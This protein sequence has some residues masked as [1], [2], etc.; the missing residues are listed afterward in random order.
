MLVIEDTNFLVSALKSTDIF[1]NDAIKALKILSP[2]D[3]QYVYP[4]VV[5]NETIFVLLRSGYNS[6]RI[7]ERINN[8]SM[9]PKVIIQDTG[10]LT[11]LRYA[12]R[13]YQSI[14]ISS[15]VSMNCVNSANDFIIAC[16]AMD[17]NAIVIS[18]DQRLITAMRDANISC[19]DFTKKEEREKLKK[20]LESPC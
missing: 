20:K 16:T 3:V 17:Y 7:R 1:H 2:F 14:P 13:Y 5:I 18:N 12:S 11:L 19:Y 6:D 10:I 4:Q 9:L 8:L 15:D